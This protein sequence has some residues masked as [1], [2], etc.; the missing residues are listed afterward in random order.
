MTINSKAVIWFSI[1]TII[2][3]SQITNSQQL[4][5]PKNS[6]SNISFLSF[7]FS[8][9]N[10]QFE[11]YE[12]N[13]GRLADIPIQQS[14]KCNF[15]DEKLKNAHELLPDVTPIDNLNLQSNII[16]DIKT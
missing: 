11:N 8:E 10:K 4:A 14:I 9:F 3:Y 2:F 1:F 7:S 12:T 6:I 16:R 5:L 13:F 15:A